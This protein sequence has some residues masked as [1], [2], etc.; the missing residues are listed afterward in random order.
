MA[1]L[2]SPVRVKLPDA[3]LNHD[4]RGSMSG[5]CHA[6]S[7]RRRL[8][9]QDGRISAIDQFDPKVVHRRSS[10]WLLKWNYN[11]R[12]EARHEASSPPGALTLRTSSAIATESKFSSMVEA[13]RP[14]ASA[15]RC[16]ICQK[17]LT[18][19][20]VHFNPMVVG[21]DVG[22][23]RVTFSIARA[24]VRRVDRGDCAWGL[25]A[26]LVH[27]CGEPWREAKRS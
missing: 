8:G 26:R 9:R 16:L 7:F 5:I 2:V 1:L 25:C 10:E 4:S 27:R 15:F 12:L 21:L 20:L 23:N 3:T 19:I 18:R 11:A 24:G 17:G 6:D 22:V 14:S 13:K